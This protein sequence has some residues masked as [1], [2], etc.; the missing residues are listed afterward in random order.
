MI[1]QH[2][3][4]SL[5]LPNVEGCINKVTVTSIRSIPEG[6]E[7]LQTNPLVMKCCETLVLQCIKDSLPSSFNPH[8]FADSTN[9]STEDAVAIAT[10]IA[11]KPFG[12][13]GELCHGLYR[14][15]FNTIIQDSLQSVCSRL[16]LLCSF[17]HASVCAGQSLC[18]RHCQ[19]LSAAARPLSC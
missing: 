5:W 4:F 12:T 17:V 2:E 1:I 3:E 16:T 11:P 15:A 18:L 13:S 10:H 6:P 7:G 8:Q 9:W 19:I 14:S